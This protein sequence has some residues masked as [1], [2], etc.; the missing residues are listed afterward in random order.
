MIEYT[1]K[2]LQSLEIL[3]DEKRPLYGEKTVLTEYL[4]YDSI[5]F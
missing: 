5:L 3:I 4:T 1:R 2:I